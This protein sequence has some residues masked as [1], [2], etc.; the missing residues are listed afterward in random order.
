MQLNKLT[1]QIRQ[2]WQLFMFVL[3]AFLY[4]L[5]FDY[6]PMYGIIIAFQNYKL[7]LGVDGSSF[8]GFANFERL[9]SSYWFPIILKNTLSISI[10]SLVISFPL[11]I[12]LSLMVNEVRSPGLKK[13]F[14]TVSYAPHFVSVVVVCSMIVLFLSPSSGMI[15]RL[16]EFFGGEKIAFMQDPNAFKWIYVLSGIWQNTGWDA[17]I[18]FA[19]L[20]AVDL[21]LL[22]AA[23]IDGANR[24]QKI[25][26]INLPALIPTILVL[27]ILRCGSVLNIGYEKVY[28]LQ[29]ATN[30]TGSEV[31][32][33]YVYKMGL[34]KSD[35]SFSTATGLFNSVV[36]CFILIVVNGII[37]KVS[38][39]SLW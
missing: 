26:H 20:S 23:E 12:I 29:N 18:Y 27:L 34:E 10:L 17:I 1:R 8:V 7:K 15:N 33:T 5:L 13:T 38:E 25:V 32:S 30:I 19:A 28:L 22:E 35:F 31:I 36:N 3:P 14:Q 39:T 21:E 9:F 2:R 37:R 4:I 16:I 11:P 6:K 24:I